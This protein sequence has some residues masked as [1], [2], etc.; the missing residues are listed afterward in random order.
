MGRGRRSHTKKTK[1]FIK[2]AGVILAIIAGVAVVVVILASVVASDNNSTCKAI[3]LKGGIAGCKRDKR[4][5]YDN[6]YFV[7]GNTANSPAPHLSETALKYVRNSSLKK[8]PNIKLFSVSNRELIGF[9]NNGDL[10]DEEPTDTINRIKKVKTDLEE[11]ITSEPKSDGAQYY[12]T[13]VRAGQAIRSDSES[14]EKSIIIVIG[15]GLSDGGILNFANGGILNN[16][17]EKVSELLSEKNAIDDEV[18]K[19][20]RILWSG[21]GIVSL[22]QA[23]LSTQELISLKNIYD[24]VL[25]ASGAAKV[26]FDDGVNGELPSIPTDK[27]V[28]PMTTDDVCYFCSVREYNDEDF[29]FDANSYEITNEGNLNKIIEKLKND[30]ARDNSGTIVITGYRA[31]VYCGDNE[32]SMYP[33]A[34]ANAIKNYILEHINVAEEKVLAVDGKIGPNDECVNSGIPNPE[35]QKTNRIVTI[36]IER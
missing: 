8:N 29:G 1:R 23:E 32:E 24:S 18:L 28:R 20:V 34:R 30:L 3:D 16:E 36:E 19:G 11:A 13:I 12:E 35:I 6:I 7:V 25:K 17:P 2:K 9:K 21:I 5:D 27:T 22:P 26:E 14:N 4:Y 10:D 15:S 33:L 31:R